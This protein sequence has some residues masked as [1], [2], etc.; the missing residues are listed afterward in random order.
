MCAD[1]VGRHLQEILEKRDAPANERG[2]EKWLVAQILQV[3]IPGKGHEAVGADEK[4]DGGEK[5]WHGKRDRGCFRRGLRG[6]SASFFYCEASARLAAKL[7][8]IYC[9]ASARLAAKLVAIYC[10]ASARLAA[11]LVAKG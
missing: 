10:E 5:L 2:D 1:A 6:G 3:A 7:V 8:A 11:K 9:E 4:E